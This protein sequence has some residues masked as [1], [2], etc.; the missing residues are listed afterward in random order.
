MNTKGT[1]LECLADLMS[2]AEKKSDSA[3]WQK[4][5]AEMCGVEVKT[6]QRWVT[7]KNPPKGLSMIRLWF[8]LDFLGY[9]VQELAG[10]PMF[11]HEVGQ[12]LSFRV[13][14][15][16]ELAKLTSYEDHPDQVLAVLRRV[17]GTS[18]ERKD[19]FSE[20]AEAYR[21]EL[22]KI[23]PTLPK[24]GVVPPG[25]ERAEEIL[26]S[27]GF[28]KVVSSTPVK[29]ESLSLP[30]GEGTRLRNE[31]VFKSLVAGLH[32][33][34]SYYTQPGVTEEEREQLREA[35]GQQEIFSLKNLLSRLCGSKAYSN[36]H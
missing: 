7:G 2:R 5:V 1:A 36:Q 16:I 23:K 26:L 19:Q 22:E 18:P 34:A 8:Y 21:E 32:T 3:N 11:L 15:L 10:L 29:A 24:L 12:I 25:Q 33:L 27:K 4:D 9:E 6:V 13:I 30:T 14:T 17:R 31:K 35:V 20:V 28:T